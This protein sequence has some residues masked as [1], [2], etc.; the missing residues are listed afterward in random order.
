MLVSDRKD[1]HRLEESL[2]PKPSKYVLIW[3]KLVE[4]IKENIL[5]PF[6]EKEKK[7]NILQWDAKATFLF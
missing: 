7:E 2:P 4:A 5:L 3:D 6:L 1:G